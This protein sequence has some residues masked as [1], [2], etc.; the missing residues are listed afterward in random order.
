MANKRLVGI[1]FQSKEAALT[2]ASHDGLDNLTEMASRFAALGMMSQETK[3]RLQTDLTALKKDLRSLMPA[4]GASLSSSVLTE[5]GYDCY[6][7]NWGENPRLDGS[8]PLDIMQHL[9][10]TPLVAVIGRTKV[11]PQDYQM[12]V[13]WLTTAHKYFDE[14]AVPTMTPEQKRE[15]HEWMEFAKPLLSRLNA[16]NTK[17]IQPA[18]ADGQHAFVL[19][20]KITSRR[21]FAGMPQDSVLPMLEP[22][23]VWGVSDADLLKKGV[24]EYRAVADEIVAKIHEKDPE[25]LP[26]ATRFP[27]RRCA[28]FARAQ[29]IPT[30]CRANWASM[31][32]WLRRGARQA[33]RSGDDFA[34]A[35][36]RT[37]EPDAVR[38]GRTGRRRQAP[39][40]VASFVDCA[41]LV[42]ACTPWIDYA[43]R[44]GYAKSHEGEG[45]GLKFDP[46]DPSE[47]KKILS[48]VHSGLEILK[49]LRTVSSATYVEDKVLVTHTEVH[50]RDLQ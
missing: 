12:S 41:G 14:L 10:G 3:A 22:A 21:W 7:Y 38:S 1:G 36:R 25:A 50:I 9:G 42:E 46:Q 11:L 40:A 13:K 18:L 16:A 26:P 27:M 24:G 5:N 35:H 8:K 32:N 45:T 31:G 43:I 33:C 39:M 30:R 23:L 47:L 17:M 20:A 48:Q 28:K 44:L 37:A 4:P 19:D 2:L 49:V 29:S 6:T 15:Y 34:R